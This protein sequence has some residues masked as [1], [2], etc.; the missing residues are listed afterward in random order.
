MREIMAGAALALLAGCYAKGLTYDEAPRPAGGQTAV[1]FYRVAGNYAGM[2]TVA[3]YLDGKK[4]A[5]IAQEGYTWVPVEPGRRELG[6]TWS[7]FKSGPELKTSGELR[8]GQQLYMRLTAEPI[9]GGTRIRM[10]AV[11]P[12]VGDADIRK[13]RFEK[14]DAR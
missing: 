13:F 4:V 14:P 7:S 8:P 2:V 11:P 6:A 10:A 9:P 5:S 3:V 12:A 1:Y